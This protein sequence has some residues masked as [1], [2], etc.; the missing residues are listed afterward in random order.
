MNNSL[1]VLLLLLLLQLLILFQLLILPHTGLL[2]YSSFGKRRYILITLTNGIAHGPR[3]VSVEPGHRS[4]GLALYPYITMNHS[5]IPDISI[6][7]PLLLLL[8]GT[9]DCSIDT[10]SEIPPRSATG[11]SVS[12][13]HMCIYNKIINFNLNLILS[14]RQTTNSNRSGLAHAP[15]HDVISLR[16]ERH[17]QREQ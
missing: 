6:A 14:T 7:L 16:E 4:T 8:R 11:T 3:I 10:V 9:P 12:H 17:R 15:G 13:K 1:V 5:V 2:N